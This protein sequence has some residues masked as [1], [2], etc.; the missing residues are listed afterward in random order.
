M[1][2]PLLEVENLRIYYKTASLPVRAV[3]GVSF[4]VKKR[5][6]LGVAGESG[7]GKSTLA[8]G[9]LRLIIPPAYVAGGR[10][11]YRGKDLYNMDDKEL[12]QIRWK[13]IAF[14]PQSSMNALN[15]TMKIYN[16]ISDVIKA[17][18][19][20]KPD[21]DL[22]NQVISLLRSVALPSRISQEYP[23]NLS[24]GMKQRV[25]I[26]M[27]MSLNPEL[28]IADEPTSAL[29]VV[30]QKGVLEFLTDLKEKEGSSLILVSHDIAILAEV[31][32]RIA[33]I[34]AG[35]IME[36]QEVMELFD[37][38]L[39][40][41]TQGLIDSVPSFSRK[42]I[43]R[44]IPGLPPD[45]RNPPAGCRFNPRCPKV[46]DICMKEEPKFNEIEPGKFVACHLYQ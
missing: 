1:E 34:Y 44:S 42:T 31:A 45:L 43:P 3:D 12:R 6:V 36:I 35:K 29:D 40:P 24:G 13:S 27:G 39:H 8:S 22:K 38:P 4:S 18:E 28:I 11:L 33:I 41:Y 26:A 10:V 32:D 21:S 46:M 15:P 17:H 14:L 7:C 19:G 2:S 9:L 30:V 5:E 23:C 25:V 37:E 16:Q 20:K